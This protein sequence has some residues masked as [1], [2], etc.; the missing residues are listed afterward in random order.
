MFGRVLPVRRELPLDRAALIVP[1]S[2]FQGISCSGRMVQQGDFCPN[3]PKSTSNR[4]QSAVRRAL[5]SERL[6]HELAVGRLGRRSTRCIASPH[7][8]RLRPTNGCPPWQGLALRRPRRSRSFQP[9]TILGC[10]QRPSSKT[11]GSAR[12]ASASVPAP[13]MS[14][15]SGVMRASCGKTA[16]PR[17]GTTGR[18]ITVAR[19]VLVAHIPSRTARFFASLAIAR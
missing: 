16:P 13:R 14:T 8:L 1:P 7:A 2:C 6:Q 19:S 11:H 18:R 15:A 3:L 9:W 5:P 12:E 4:S 17:R 10:S